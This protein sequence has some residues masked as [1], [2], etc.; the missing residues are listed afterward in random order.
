MRRRRIGGV[1]TTILGEAK[2]KSRARFED[3]R[4]EREGIVIGWAPLTSVG[5][6]LLLIGL[7]FHALETH[8][9]PSP[10]ETAPIP[11]TFETPKSRNEARGRGQ[12]LS[13]PRGGSPAGAEALNR[14][15][16]RAGHDEVGKP[17][18]PVESG[19]PAEAN[20][21]RRPREA[22]PV[23]QR[24][25]IPEPQGPIHEPRPASGSPEGDPSGR[26]S[27]E[28]ALRDFRRSLGAP[29]AGAGEDPRPGGERAGEDDFGSPDL[30]PL[31]HT[32][33]GFGNLQFESRDYDWTD[34]A[35]QIYVAIWRAWHHRLYLTTDAFEKWSY[36]QRLSLLDHQSGIRFTIERNGQLLGV[37]MEAASGCIPLDDSAVAALQEVVLPPLPS[38]FPREAET[39]HAR[40]IAQGEIRAMRPTLEYLR[41][42][43]LF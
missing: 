20:G 24:E 7:F 8:R 38:D 15:G 28:R 27:I 2:V 37:T 29:P 42:R 6:H 5:I 34:Y 31:P 1:P 36:Q 17:L 32:G 39:V 23:P 40:F 26:F 3:T 14:I 33:F 12:A 4:P 13:A 43:G 25:G 11:V 21:I 30:P 9:G 22:A 41:S 35:R 10:P 18:Q 19:P 16:E